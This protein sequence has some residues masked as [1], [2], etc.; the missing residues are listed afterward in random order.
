MKPEEDRPWVPSDDFHEWPASAQ[1]AYLAARRRVHKMKAERDAVRA[2]AQHDAL[3]VKAERDA[4]RRKV[5][6]DGVGAAVVHALPVDSLEQLTLSWEQW[7]DGRIHRLKRGKHFSGEVSAV[8]EEARLAARLSGRGVLQLREQMGPKYQYVWV[9]FTDYSVS[10]G[11]P[12]PCGGRKLDRLH[13][14]LA[15]CRRCGKTLT[16][17]PR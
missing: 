5:E 13:A 9:Q 10:I 3:R 16:L 8:I 17:S 14:S 4:L 1:E 15:R 12:C 2:K 11:D 7:M 6:E